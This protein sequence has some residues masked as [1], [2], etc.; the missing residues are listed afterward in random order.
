VGDVADAADVIGKAVLDHVLTRVDSW[1]DSL[2]VTADTNQLA[3]QL[4]GSITGAGL[5]EREAL[6]LFTDVIEPACL[7]V[8]H[9]RFLSF[10]PA[11]PTSMALLGDV[12]TSA[13]RIYGGSWM[14]GAGAIQAENDVLAWIAGFCGLPDTAGGV[15]VPGGT[16]GNT[17][18]LIAARHRW[19]TLQSPSSHSG[20]MLIAAESVHPS[21]PQAAKAMDAELV[22]LP[23]DSSGRLDRRSLEAVVRALGNDRH[24]VFAVCA[25]AGTTNAGLI[26]DLGAAADAVA[27]LGCWFHVDGAYGLAAACSHRYRHLFAGVERADSLIV[28]PHKWLFGPF[29]SC[30]LLY[31]DPALARAAH[32]QRAPYLEV[33][34]GTEDEPAA[35]WNPSDYA[36]HLSRR[37]RGLPTWFSLVALGTEAYAGAID[38]TMSLTAEAA[39]LI[40]SSGHLQLLVEPQLSTVVFRRRGWTREGHADWSRKT[41]ANGTAA[42]MPTTWNGEVALRICIV[43]PRTTIEDI[44]AV[45]GSLL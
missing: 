7:R 40:D 28:D 4:D 43:N 29:D 44:Q 37:P 6:R 30:A 45:V 26:D 8:D 11:A 14:E 32:Q 33:L 25:T 5:G 31:R 22:L 10:V 34:N 16:N 35:G 1:D 18:A 3:R 36:L 21:V 27:E 2:G 15:F 19:R 38:A 12:L 39:E 9:P 17:S 42:V 23:G 20:G 41:L 13:A 24:K